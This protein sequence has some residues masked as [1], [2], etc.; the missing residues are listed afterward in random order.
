MATEVSM[1]DQELTAS[2]DRLETQ[3]RMH[4]LQRRWM[5][6]ILEASG[7][8]ELQKSPAYKTLKP[9]ARKPLL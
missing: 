8:G 3:Q 9:R 4:D 6:M 5:E 1:W 7:A 2:R